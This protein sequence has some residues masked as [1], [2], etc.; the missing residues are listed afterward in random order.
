VDKE[1]GSGFLIGYKKPPRQTQFKP[2]Q[3]GNPTGR[4]KKRTSFAESIEKEL[5]TRITVNEGGERRKITK[6]QAIAKQQ[7]NKALNGDLK[8]TALLMRA[9][10]PRESEQIDNPSP[11]LHA[12]RAIHAKHEAADQKATRI[13]AVSDLP[14]NS[15]DDDNDSD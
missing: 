8:A 10:E 5:N 12:M 7:T 3:S 1:K 11:L 9:I 13:T 14:G 4:P 6:L 15:E 2:G